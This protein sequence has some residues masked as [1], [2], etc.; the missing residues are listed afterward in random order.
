MVFA[1]RRLRCIGLREEI[2]VSDLTQFTAADLTAIREKVKAIGPWFHQIDLGNGLR[3]RDIAPAPGS[4]PIDHPRARWNILENVI[5]ADLAG[6]RFLDIGCAE[7]FF[8]IELARRGAGVVAMDAAPGM[9][10]RLKWLIEHFRIET[11]EPRVGQIETLAGSAEKFDAVLMLALLYHLPWPL[12]GLEIASKLT[13]TLFLETIVHRGDDPVLYLRPPIPGVQ[14]VPKW[15]PTEKCVIAMLKMVGFNIVT[16][17]DRA[18]A[19][20]G[21]YIAR[22]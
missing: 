19:E 10:V 5:P 7:G 2:G 1:E 14:H 17:L 16:V 18:D 9:I 15:I 8:A 6:K 20:R 4:Q 21:I 11:I 12:Q 3:T 13:D 22:R